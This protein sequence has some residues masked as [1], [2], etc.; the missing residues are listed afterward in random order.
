MI[1]CPRCGWNCAEE[2]H[3]PRAGGYNP[4]SAS[5]LESAE[6]YR[7][8]VK[9]HA[10]GLETAAAAWVH[11]DDGLVWMAVQEYRS[12]EERYELT[13]WSNGPTRGEVFRNAAARRFCHSGFDRRSVATHWWKGRLSM[14]Y[15]ALWFEEDTP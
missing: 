2:A 9:C 8:D 5:T 12:F 6:P 4:F 7:L 10:C 1:R 15:D 3:A 14:V 13:R 11:V